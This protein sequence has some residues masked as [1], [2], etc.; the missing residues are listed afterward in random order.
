MQNIRSEFY[1]NVAK[2]DDYSNKS[3]DWFIKSLKYE[4]GS[5]E[6]QI[7]RLKEKLYFKEAMKHLKEANREL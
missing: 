6:W 2:F 1:I 7:C 5:L 4:Y 3:I